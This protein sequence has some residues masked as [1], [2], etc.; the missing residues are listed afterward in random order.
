VAGALIAYRQGHLV[1]AS[2]PLL[3]S[4]NLI[5][6]VVLGGIGVRWGVALQ[7]ALFIA[8]PT[9]LEGAGDWLLLGGSGLLVLIIG[10]HPEGLGGQLREAI[11]KRRTER[12]ERPE[13]DRP[14]AVEGA[15]SP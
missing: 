14:L 1:A 9:Y 6:Y 15:P 10:L 3:L 13:P 4:F 11:H 7:T 12:A 8:L 2:F 5:L